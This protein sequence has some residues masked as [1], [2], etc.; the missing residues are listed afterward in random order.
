MAVSFSRT[1]P[2]VKSAN[3]WRGL[4]RRHSVESA[5]KAFA[6]KNMVAVIHRAD[7]SAVGF[8]FDV[9]N[10]RVARVTYPT[11]EWLA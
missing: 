11:V 6:R 8:F 4:A 3:E 9:A 2:F 5:A 10:N 1:A 7:D